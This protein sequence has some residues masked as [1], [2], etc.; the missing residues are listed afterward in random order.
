MKKLSILLAVGLFLCALSSVPAQANTLT[1]GAAP[2]SPD[3]FTDAYLGNPANYIADTGIVSVSTGGGA[4]LLADFRSVVVREPSGVL[5]F[6]YEVHNTG[7][8]GVN[9][10]IERVTAINFKG[11]TVDVGYADESV[12]DL[13][14]G[15]A[16]TTPTTV[17]LSSIGDTVG[18]NFDALDPQEDSQVLVIKTDAT[19]FGQGVFQLLDGNI[20]QTSAFDPVPEP[21]TMLL[22]GSGLIGLAAY[23]RRR[24][25][26]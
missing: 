26:K 7:A 15:S 20:G 23:A 13:I 21:A 12:V 24:F 19:L 9:E 10:S 5:D 25:K 4:P 1:P 17:N 11:Y 3:V 6:L 2:V 22:L 18:W 14:T 8:A 16:H